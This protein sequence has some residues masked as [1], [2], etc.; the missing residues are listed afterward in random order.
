M[1]CLACGAEMQLREV[2]LADIPT[3][4]GFERHTFLRSACAQVARRLVIC[5]AKMP[6]LIRWSHQSH[7]RHP[8]ATSER[9]TGGWKPVADCGREAPQH[10]GV[11][12]GSG[13]RRLDA[14]GRAAHQGPQRASGGS[15]GL[16]V[17][18]DGR[19]APQQTDGAQGAS[20]DWNITSDSEFACSAACRER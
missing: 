17:G 2:V 13:G 14:N 11:C 1:Q 10:P 3:M 6:S 20:G 15:E 16:G 19:E 4:P 9:A 12:R 18:E 7:P 8:P 5:R